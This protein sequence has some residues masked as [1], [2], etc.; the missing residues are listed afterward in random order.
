MVGGGVLVF[1]RG[2]AEIFRT[3]YL[4]SHKEKLVYLLAGRHKCFWIR[5]AWPLQLIFQFLSRTQT[6]IDCS[7]FCGLP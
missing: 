5:S 4:V 6:K 7:A 2:L 1:G 3:G